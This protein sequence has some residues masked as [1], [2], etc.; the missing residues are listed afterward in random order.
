MAAKKVLIITYY[1]PPAGGAGVQRWLKMAKYL[2]Q[3]GIEPFVLT[4]DE[5]YAS[6]PVVDPSF[7]DEVSSET[8]VYRTK[9]F[10]PLR[11]YGKLFGKKKVPYS[12]FTNVNTHTVGSKLSRWIRGNFFIPDARKGWNKYALPKALEIIKAENIETVITTG[13][14]HSTHLIGLQL[15]NRKPTLKWIAD[16]RD[17]W[18]DI[19][20]YDDLLHTKRSKAKDLKLEKVV[21]N[22]SDL[23]LAVCP[24]NQKLLAQKL[25]KEQRGKIKLITNGFD[26]EDFEGVNRTSSDRI[27]KIGYTGTLAQ[28]YDVLPIFT[29]LA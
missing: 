28:S 17:P 3:F 1:W 14:P 19:Y 5:S 24:S 23:V 18:T 25:P 4:V 27:L 2:P 11:I 6:Y 9:S 16:F 13:P 26:E 12:G 20:Y 15:K 22:K 10:E 29:I 7:L 8:K 21:L